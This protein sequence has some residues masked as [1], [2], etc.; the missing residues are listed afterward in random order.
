MNCHSLIQKKITFTKFM[1]WLM[2]VFCYLQMGFGYFQFKYLALED[3]SCCYVFTV[4]HVKTQLLNS[5]AK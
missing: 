1:F 4:L 3:F 2:L 5:G